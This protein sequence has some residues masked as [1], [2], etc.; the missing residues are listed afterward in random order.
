LTGFWGEHLPLSI[1]RIAST[2]VFF[3][4]GPKIGTFGT[5]YPDS[6][7]VIPTVT[8]NLFTQGK[9]KENLVA[10]SFQPTSEELTTVGEL[11]FG[12][13]DPSKYTGNIH[14]V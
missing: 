6:N 13:T 8:D 4:I 7:S 1:F 3:S 12:G 14:H 10:V 5:L 11:T 2:T 9:I